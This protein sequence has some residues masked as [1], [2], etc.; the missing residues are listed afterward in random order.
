MGHNIK[1]IVLERRT[2]N[3]MELDHLD[4]NWL[5]LE[6]NICIIPLTPKLHDQIVYQ[7][8]IENN[9]GYTGFVYLGASIESYLKQLSMLGNVAYI[10]TEYFGGTGNQSA[11]FYTDQKV[12]SG[13]LTTETKWDSQNETYVTKPEGKGAINQV[14]SLLGVK[15][16]KGLSDEFE[17][18]GLTRYR[19]N[20]TILEKCK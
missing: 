10:E 15:I 11:I 14:L 6:Q 18:I 4:F 12:I 5:L 8:K 16:E 1:A 3:K 13:P 19:T 2:I 9:D 20:E 7:S 17:S